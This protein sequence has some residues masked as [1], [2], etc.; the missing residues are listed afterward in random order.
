MGCAGRIDICDRRAGLY[1]RVL[2]AIAALARPERYIAR[3][4]AHLSRGL[5]GSLLAPIAPP[6]HAIMS[7]PPA[8]AAIAD[9]S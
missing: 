6:A 8:R 7:A 3:F 9:P 1:R 5:C 2:R 4:A